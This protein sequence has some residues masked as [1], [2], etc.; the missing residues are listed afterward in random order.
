MNESVFEDTIVAPITGT[1]SAPVAVLRISGPAAWAIGKQIGAD[2]LRGKDPEPRRVYFTQIGD[3]DEGFL[4][5]F[6]RGK[7]YTGEESIELSL[8]GS[9]ANVS[10][11]LSLIQSLGARL[12]RP[13]EFTERRFYHG[14]VDLTQAEGV[15]ATVRALT[16]RESRRASLLRQGGLR[17][18]IDQLRETL[19]AI[20]AT[21]EASVEFTE[22]VGPLDEA[23]TRKDLESLLARV[24]NLVAQRRGS[25]ILR[26]GYRVCLVGRANVGKSSLL[27]CLLGDDRAIVTEIP[28]TTRDTIEEQIEVDGYRIVLT[29]T[30]GIRET[31]D[32]VEQIGVERTVRA[33]EAADEIWM[34]FEAPIGWTDEDAAI[35]QRLD[36]APDLY[37]ANKADLGYATTGLPQ[38]VQ[39]VSAKTGEGIEGLLSSLIERLAEISGGEAPL[40]N[41]RHA[42]SLQAAEEH[43]V[44]A[45]DALRTEPPDLV[46]VPLYAAMD[47][48]GEITGETAP[49]QIIERVFRDFCVGK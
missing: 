38:P 28:G 30:A 7:S 43:L 33:L 46:C 21:I 31:E 41:D 19:S 47:A 17:R 26:E 32:V 18:E 44:A 9:R 39:L 42:V 1:A 35:L 36:R 8:H 12:A 40:V 37:L 5:F 23:G 4:V 27:N 22:E 14:L 24:R 45:L 3:F 2:A 13:G 29:D 49:D 10:L 48:L 11:A 20:L 6:E 25:R 34:V 15:E 16:D